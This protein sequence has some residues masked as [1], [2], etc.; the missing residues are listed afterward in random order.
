LYFPRKDL[1]HI[2]VKNLYRD[3]FIGIQVQGGIKKT[4]ERDLD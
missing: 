2:F 1:G 3:I 4:F